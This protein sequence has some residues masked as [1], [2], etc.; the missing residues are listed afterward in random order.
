M[1]A[2]SRKRSEG[3]RRHTWK[4]MSRQRERAPRS[5]PPDGAKA[6]GRGFGIGSK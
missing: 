5:Q 4:D 3:R 1:G 2:E 6:D